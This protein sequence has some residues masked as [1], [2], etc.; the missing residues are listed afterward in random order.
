MATNLSPTRNQTGTLPA[1]VSVKNPEAHIS[2]VA[3]EFLGYL[4]TTFTNLADQVTPR[5]AG[6]KAGDP[7][8]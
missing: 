1:K 4:P 3:D 8:L 7:N 5:Q 6:H 2:N